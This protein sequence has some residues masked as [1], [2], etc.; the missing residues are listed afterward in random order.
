MGKKEG[1]LYGVKIGKKRLRGLVR[2]VAILCCLLLFSPI[3]AGAETNTCVQSPS[4]IISW[5]PGDGNANDI[6]DGNPGVLYGGATFAGGKVGEAFSFAARG[7]MVKIPHNSNLNLESLPGSTFEGWFKSSAVSPRRNNMAGVI[8][9]HT[10][11]VYAGWFFTTGQGCFIGDHY[12]G[13]WGVGGLDLNDGRFHH[14]ACVKDGTR[15]REYIDGALISEDIGPAVGTPVTQPV[16]I[17]NIVTG[18]CADHQMFGLVD[19]LAVLNKALAANEIQAIF[20]AGSAGC[21]NNPPVANAG[22]D[23][24]I[25]CAGSS[26]ASV[27]LNGSGSSDPDDDTLIYTWTWTGGSAEGVSPT[28]NLPLGTRAVTLTV[29]DGK[30]TATDTVN[31]TVQDKTPPV[32]TATGGS[33]NWYNANVISSFSATDSC[34][35]VKE[36]HYTVNGTETVVSGESASLTL[37]ND[38]TYNIIYYSIDKAGNAESSNSMT[39]KIDKT[40]PILNLSTGTN[41]LWPPNHKMSDVTIGGNATDAT[42]G[43]ASVAFTVV[44]EYGIVQP[45]ISNFN[46]AIQL[47]AW[48]EGTDKDGRH[49]TITA[50]AADAAGNKTT[51]FTTVL[52]PHDQGKK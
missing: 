34:S 26:G 18:A 50:V 2:G 51:T 3:Y 22:L 14:F 35:G 28:V 49:Y 23:Q 33:D 15:Y 38:G 10:C 32:T 8:A 36:I 5:W 39:V 16:Q 4:S 40:P 27:T 20:N 29:S 45:S 25:E 21:R 1:I 52:V 46:T 31:I 6:V 30:A 48:R 13:G 9:K 44:D 37:T 11:T 12:I 24:V 41:T 42:S 17:G 7:D 19:E 43:I 47:E